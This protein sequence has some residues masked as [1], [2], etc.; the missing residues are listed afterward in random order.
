[1]RRKL[2]ALVLALL[3]GCAHTGA[4]PPADRDAYRSAEGFEGAKWGQTPEE[5]KPLVEGA[6]HPDPI[7]YR[8]HENIEGRP[9]W[10]T[11]SFPDGHLATVTV[12]YDP[13]TGTPGDF[14]ASFDVLSRKLGTPLPPPGARN[15]DEDVALTVAAVAA[16]VLVVGIIVAI[17]AHSGG[18]G[19]HVGNVGHVASGASHVH[20]AA[21]ILPAVP[22]AGVFH[23]VRDACWLDF[24]AV[25]LTLDAMQI[26]IIANDVNGQ[27]LPPPPS[28]GG[29]MAEWRTPDTDV[30]LLGVNLGT[31]QASLVESYRSV[32]LTPPLPTDG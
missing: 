5:L 10:V 17:V 8:H 18:G 9:A 23:P 11:Y 16:A 22:P 1:M 21:A 3:A 32:A 25:R 4:L 29:W 6:E 2:S 14:D 19:G 20:A 12:Q 13:P 27:P 24:A 15:H 7:T 28:P 31:P 30:L 26:A